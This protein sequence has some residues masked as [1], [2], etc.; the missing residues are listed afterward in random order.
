[1]ARDPIADRFQKREKQSRL[2]QYDKRAK[3]KEEIE[4]EEKLIKETPKV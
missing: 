1:M 2:E 3:T 4:A